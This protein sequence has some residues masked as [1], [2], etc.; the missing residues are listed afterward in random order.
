MPERWVA[1]P[2][3]GKDDAETVKSLNEVEK[4][5]KAGA[6]R[7]AV[8]GI[9]VSESA[10]LEPTGR[11]GWLC[12]LV[13]GSSGVRIHNEQAQMLCRLFSPSS[14][15]ALHRSSAQ[16]PWELPHSLGSWGGGKEECLIRA[17]SKLGGEGGLQMLINTAQLVRNAVL[18]LLLQPR[19][20]ELG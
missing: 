17:M 9:S 2:K 13:M 11:P 19:I 12:S 8:D 16:V 1:G 3:A 4:R 20:Y 15:T 7:G 14:G 5:R 10:A 6:S 18:P